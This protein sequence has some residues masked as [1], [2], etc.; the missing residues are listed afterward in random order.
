MFALPE[1]LTEAALR[2]GLRHA[3]RVTFDFVA[4]AEAHS[5]MFV[6]VEEFGPSFVVAACSFEEAER[7]IAVRF[8]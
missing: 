5:I 4:V 8:P 1:S 6:A 3:A 7:A 2:L